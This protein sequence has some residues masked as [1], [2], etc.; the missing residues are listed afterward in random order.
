MAK[1]TKELTRE[2]KIAAAYKKASDFSEVLLDMDVLSAILES[3]TGRMKDVQDGD[4]GTDPD[5]IF[6]DDK[7]GYKA[8]GVDADAI[9]NSV[10]AFYDR[11]AAH[12]HV[13]PDYVAFPDQNPVSY[14]KI[15]T[16]SGPGI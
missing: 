1:K 4:G 2:E 12:T 16:Y 15:I 9:P 3:G 11:V 13:V 7:L 8:V 6:D 14:L 5:F 10:F